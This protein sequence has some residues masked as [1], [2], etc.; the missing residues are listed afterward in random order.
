M[1][2]HHP[3]RIWF[4][5]WRKRCVCGCGWFPCPDAVTAEPPPVVESLRLRRPG[6]RRNRATAHD[7]PRRGN[8]RP[9]ATEG[10]PWHRRRRG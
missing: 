1:R 7:G 4:M 8:E 10:P 3:V 5:P 2:G 9:A 6:P